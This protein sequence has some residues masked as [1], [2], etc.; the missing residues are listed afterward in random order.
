MTRKSR[1]VIYT[2]KTHTEKGIFATVLGILSFVSL[3]LLTVL[4]YVNKGEIKNSYG[5]VAFL[6]TL[7][8]A[9]G[10]ILGSMGKR[11]PDRFYLFAY[12]GIASNVVDLCIISAIL[13]AGI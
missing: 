5:A 1:K 8:S 2:K 9:A 12:L 4:S 10:I 3:V 11:E 13:Y 7:F 6:C